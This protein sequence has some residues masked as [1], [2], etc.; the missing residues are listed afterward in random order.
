MVFAEAVQRQAAVDQSGDSHRTPNEL[1]YFSSSCS[2]CAS[3]LQ[4][5]EFPKHVTQNYSLKGRVRA[6]PGWTVSLLLLSANF[7]RS[8]QGLEREPN[9]GGNKMRSTLIRGLFVLC[10]L[11]AGL[12][13]MALAQDTNRCRFSPAECRELRADR[14][15]IRADRRDIRGDVREIRQ[16]RH[17]TR[18]DVREYRQDRRERASQRELRADRRE[19]RSDRREV[20]GDHREFR[21]D[22]RDLRGDRRDFRHDR[23]DARH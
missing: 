23:R 22:R 19:I 6:F 8:A 20:F 5:R 2:H 17:E 4:Q 14:R 3:N 1:E 9:N 15:E 10:L 21:Q 12:S 18:S 7:M 16:D 13:A 11:L